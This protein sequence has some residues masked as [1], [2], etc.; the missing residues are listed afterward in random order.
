MATLDFSLHPSQQLIWNS[1][2]RF[3]CVVAG[4][5]FGK[6][7]LMCIWLLCKALESKNSRG[8]DLGADNIVA[9]MAPTFA[10]AHR[11]FWP[12]LVKM[13]DPVIAEKWE[14][15]GELKLTN[16]RRIRL[17]GMDN[18]DAARGPSYSAVGFDEYAD[19][20]ERAWKE[21]IRPALMDVEGEAM[22]IG[23]PKG[24]NHFFKLYHDA[25]TDE[26]GEWEGFNF[27]STDNPLLSS[28]ELG[29]LT[30]DM[31]SEQIHQEIE[32]SF[33]SAEGAVFKR[34][35]FKFSAEEPEEGQYFIAVDLAGFRPLS[36]S[37]Q[38]SIKRLDETAIAVVKVNDDGWWVKEIVHGQ[39]DTRKT[40]ITIIN[41]ARRHQAYTIGIEKGAL[42]NAV[43]PYLEDAMREFGR[44]LYIRPVTHGNQR[45]Q[46]RIAWALQGRA[47]KGR[48]TLNPGPWAEKL[49]DQCMDFPDPRAKDDLLDALAY[50]DQLAVTDY[51]STITSQ[52]DYRPQDV[53]SGY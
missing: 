24:K 43:A 4:R 19:M 14:N 27:Q 52:R 45:K 2:A 39:W 40:A 53:T 50:I 29:S 22:F 18:P 35:W 16:G 38:K 20:P 51:G 47:E 46:D 3:R 32:A 7:H 34:E 17:F 25:V 23:T 44:F 49:I 28:T 33:T 5:R 15:T 48:I 13:A 8:Y 21:I 1:P 41:T 26:T 12:K 30:R 6:S 37:H 10:M 11:D 9:Y 31:S 36:G 42:A